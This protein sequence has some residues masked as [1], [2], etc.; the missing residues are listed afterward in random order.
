MAKS[1]SRAQTAAAAV[2]AP[3]Q[4][5]VPEQQSLVSPEA[6]APA[7]PASHDTT[8]PPALLDFM[9]KGWKPQSG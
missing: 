3:A 6:E 9:M 8:P 1:K 2:N 7:K 4:E 5:Q